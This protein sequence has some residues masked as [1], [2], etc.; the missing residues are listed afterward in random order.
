[1]PPLTGL[2]PSS[3]RNRALT[4]WANECRRF[5][6]RLLVCRFATGALPVSTTELFTTSSSHCFQ[7]DL[8]AGRPDLPAKLIRAY[9]QF[10]LSA[11]SVKVIRHTMKILLWKNSSNLTRSIYFTSHAVRATVLLWASSGFQIATYAWAFALRM[12]ETALI[13]WPLYVGPTAS[14]RALC[15][16]TRITTGWIGKSDG[17]ARSAGASS[18]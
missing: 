2:I 5:A 12:K 9:F 16:P 8:A 7:F 4:C 14:R 13:S 11:A 3:F 18:R 1:V 6:T 17:N 15:A 10:A